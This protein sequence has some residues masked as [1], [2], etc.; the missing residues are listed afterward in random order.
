VKPIEVTTAPAL[1]TMPTSG[2]RYIVAGDVWVEVPAETTRADMDKYVIM[3]MLTPSPQD[4]QVWEVQ[5]SRGNLYKLTRTGEAW[6]C[7]CAG[8]AYRRRC[9]HIE[10]KKNESR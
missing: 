2:K 1:L 3:T 5:G 8:F 9:R 6:T 4:A 7:S 10:T